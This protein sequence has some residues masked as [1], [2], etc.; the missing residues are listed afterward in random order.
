MQC[1]TYGRNH[2]CGPWLWSKQANWRAYTVLYGGPLADAQ[3]LSDR[4]G[5][6]ACVVDDYGN[7]VR[8]AP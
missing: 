3:F 7:L 2:F 5:L 8:L 6:F 4:A 1:E